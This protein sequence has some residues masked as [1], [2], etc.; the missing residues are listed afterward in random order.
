[1]EN[2]DSS[3]VYWMW[4]S[5][6]NGVGPVIAKALLDIFETPLNIY[7]ATKSELENIS[8][9]G[10]VTADVIFSS[11]SLVGS[12]EMLKKCEKLNITV[13]TYRDYLYP[14]EV[15]KIKQAPII[16]Y[17]RGTLIENSI[18]IA[19]VGSRRCTEYGKRL[20]VEAGEFLAQSNIPVI[21]GM[22]KGIDG[23]AHTACLKS[24]GYTIA[25]LGCGLDICY[26]KEHMELMQRI[27]EKGAI[28]SEYPPGIKP[29]ARHFPMRNRLIS[30]W[31]K[32]LLVVEAGEK[33][34]SLLTAAYAK[35]QNREVFAAP[36][37]IY[38]TESFGT[39]K[40]IYEGA[41]IYLNP[42]Q[43]LLNPIRKPGVNN[44]MQNSE[45]V[46][47]ELTV[48]EKAILTKIE[49]SPMTLGELLVDLKMDKSD[50]LETI[51][52][53]ELKGM[54]RNVGGYIKKKE[55]F[56]PLRLI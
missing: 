15:K 52:I 24:D 39:N 1:M 10:R 3:L 35:E 34:G 25:I 19:I 28:V 47:C 40:L 33:S 2:Y 13:L 17:Y 6:I 37:S 7:T 30:A 42:S 49:D 32:K 4:L 5:Q 18:G 11:K 29:D 53:M 41:K 36:N 44:K 21:S 31:C 20:T 16:L 54:I 26:P 9:I 27:I 38:R 51:S 45:P 22:A 8:G 55:A 48:L 14:I 56:L 50:I 23:Y 46:G 12:E 43:L